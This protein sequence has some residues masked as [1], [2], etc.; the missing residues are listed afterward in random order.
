[1]NERKKKEEKKKKQKR[2]GGNKGMRGMNQ[3]KENKNEV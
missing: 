2:G 3:V 1:V